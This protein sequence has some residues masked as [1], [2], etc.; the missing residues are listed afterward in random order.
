[1]MSG[2]FIECRRYYEGMCPG[3]PCE[4][5]KHDAVNEYNDM[6]FTIIA[7]RLIISALLVAVVTMAVL[8]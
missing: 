5:C 7:Q 6:R 4:T 3:G 8:A 2:R 1:M